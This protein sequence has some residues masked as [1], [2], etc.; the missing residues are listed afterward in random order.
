MFVG[1]YVFLSTP[2]TKPT[3]NPTPRPIIM[4]MTRINANLTTAMACN[5]NILYKVKCIFLFAAYFDRFISYRT[6]TK[7][8]VKIKKWT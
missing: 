2:T 5:Y 7:C 8:E 6:Y 1:L 3:K 4:I